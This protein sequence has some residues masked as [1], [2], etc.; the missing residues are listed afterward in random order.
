MKQKKIS[1]KKFRVAA[2]H[3]LQYIASP[4][5]R[6]GEFLVRSNSSLSTDISNVDNINMME[7]YQW[8]VGFSDAESSFWIQ[9]VLNSKNNISKITWVFSVELHID[10][11]DVLMYIKNNLGSG[12]IRVYKDKCIFTVTSVEGTNHLISIFD[13]Y[14][15][16]STKYLDYLNYKEAFILYQKRDKVLLSSNI[17]EAEK[18]TKKILEL[19][20]TMNTKR[21]NTILPKDH[22]IVITKSWLLGYIEGDGSF[23]LSRTDIDPVFSISA[24]A[25]QLVLFENIKAFLE[26]NLGFDKYSQFKL[27]ITKAIAI[28][29]V[30]ARE[31]GKPSVILSIKNIKILNNYFIPYFENMSF[32]TKKGLDSSFLIHKLILYDEKMCETFWVAQERESHLS[33]TRV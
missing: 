32:I 17:V 13:K 29:K 1:Q 15:L 9:V 12:N 14:N 4:S 27:L 33:G 21:T 6:L 26:N 30:K 18:F 3:S 10:D 28:N 31:I 2:T 25:E 5:L 22:K 20:N 8:F 11:Y 7:F 24:S 19:K 23:F 16:N